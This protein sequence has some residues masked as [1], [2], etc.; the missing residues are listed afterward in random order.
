MYLVRGPLTPN[1]CNRLETCPRLRGSLATRVSLRAGVFGIV[2]VASTVSSL[3]G[4]SKAPL[5]NALDY[6][7]Q[8]A[9]RASESV[10]GSVGAS[11][12]T[13]ETADKSQT[14]N[15]AAPARK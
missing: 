13:I 1:Y 12:S 8:A 2:M 7:A 14:P 6:A 5:P 11:T 15:Q 10:Q 3:M 4:C 9:Q